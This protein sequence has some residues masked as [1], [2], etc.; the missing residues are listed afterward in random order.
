MR[1]AVSE[2]LATEDH[3]T[4]GSREALNRLQAKILDQDPDE[5]MLEEAAARFLKVA[6][7]TLATWRFTGQGPF[8]VKLSR[9]CVRYRRKDLI[10][11]VEKKIKAS[12]SEL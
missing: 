6:P 1:I 10:D 3:L 5:L 7:K 9:R 12:T 2:A 8:F 4:N 11:W